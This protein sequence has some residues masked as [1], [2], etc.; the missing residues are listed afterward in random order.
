[1]SKPE[2]RLAAD[3]LTSHDPAERDKQR[4]QV[5]QGV[6]ILQRLREILQKELD[7]VEREE[8]TDF[9]NPAWPYRRAALDGE[10]KALRYLKKL[11]PS[12]EFFEK[13][14]KKR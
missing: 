7:R 9:D 10:K 14:L 12:D 5:I 1:M 13:E 2:E 8:T 11:I 6:V 4:A 3:W